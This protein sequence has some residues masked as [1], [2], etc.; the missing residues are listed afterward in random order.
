MAVVIVMSELVEVG[1]G[2]DTF[3]KSTE[4]QFCPLVLFVKLSSTEVSECSSTCRGSTS[5]EELDAYNV[6]DV[7]LLLDEVSRFDNT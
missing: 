5:N 3:A 7:E 2:E 4:E 1:S 6:L